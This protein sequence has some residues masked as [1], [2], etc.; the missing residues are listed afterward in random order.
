MILGYQDLWPSEHEAH[1][2]AEGTLAGVLALARRAGAQSHELTPDF[3]R[4]LLW[5]LHAFN[6]QVG[7]YASDVAKS[8]T[9]L[10]PRAERAAAQ[11]AL[12]TALLDMQGPLL[13][14]CGWRVRL[15]PGA[16]VG[17]AL[18]ELHR[19]PGFGPWCA[20][21]AAEVAKLIK[22]RPYRACTIPG[23]S[24]SSLQYPDAAVLA[25]T[26]FPNLEAFWAGPVVSAPFG[27]NS[28]TVAY[29]I[30]ESGLPAVAWGED[31]VRAGARQP[32]RKRL[33]VVDAAT[34]LPNKQ[35]HR[36]SVASRF[37]T[38]LRGMFGGGAAA[39]SGVLLQDPSPGGY[40]EGFASDNFAEE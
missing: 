24:P 1:R 8:F 26:V 37:H 12:Q 40:E 20:E 32:W 6:T 38:A 14:R 33:R 27:P 16:E 36:P 17:P 23:I 29:P 4:T 39:G 22:K 10:L 34:E 28:N 31:A 35:A 15:A 21:A 9:A 30:S 13:E 19:C 7:S 2:C 25:A 5:L 3:M 18:A 11:A